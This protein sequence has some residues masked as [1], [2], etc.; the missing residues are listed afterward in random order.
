MPSSIDVSTISEMV[1]TDFVEKL[2]AKRTTSTD[3]A[4]NVFNAVIGYVKEHPVS[5]MRIMLTGQMTELAQHTGIKSLDNSIGRRLT[6]FYRS[7][8]ADLGMT[9]RG[10]VFRSA[11][12][13]VNVDDLPVDQFKIRTIRPSTPMI[14][15]AEDWKRY[16]SEQMTFAME[17]FNR[18]AAL[19]SRYLTDFEH[20]GF[21]EN[22]A[23]NLFGLF[24][25]TDYDEAKIKIP[26]F[27]RINEQGTQA[28]YIVDRD[29]T[30]EADI[31]TLYANY[32]MPYKEYY[33]WTGYELERFLD[34]M[35]NDPDGMN[36]K[37]YDG[38]YRGK[39]HFVWDTINDLEFPKYLYSHD[40]RTTADHY[41][42]TTHQLWKILERF[43]EVKQYAEQCNESSDII[44]P[45]MLQ[46]LR[47]KESDYLEYI[48]KDDSR[49]LTCKKWLAAND[50]NWIE[51]KTFL[52]GLGYVRNTLYDGRI[53]I[54]S[55]DDN[56]AMFIPDAVRISD[57]R[58]TKLHLMMIGNLARDCVPEHIDLLKRLN[59][60]TNRLHVQAIWEQEFDLAQAV[61]ADS[62]KKRKL[63]GELSYHGVG[64]VNAIDV[65]ELCEFI[66]SHTDKETIEYYH[67]TTTP[68]AFMAYLTLRHITR[69]EIQE[70]KMFSNPFKTRM[71]Q[72]LP[73]DADRIYNFGSSRSGRSHQQLWKDATAEELQA[74]YERQAVWSNYQSNSNLRRKLLI[75]MERLLLHENRIDSHYGLVYRELDDGTVEIPDFF[76]SVPGR[77]CDVLFI[78]DEIADEASKKQIMHQFDE[79]RRTNI[80]RSGSHSIIGFASSKTDELYEILSDPAVTRTTW[81][82]RTLKQRCCYLKDHKERIER[83]NCRRKKQESENAA[84][85]E[86]RNRRVAREAEEARIREEQDQRVRDIASLVP[87]SA[88]LSSGFFHYIENKET[89]VSLMKYHVKH[90]LAFLT[91]KDDIP[92]ELENAYNEYSKRRKLREE[93]LPFMETIGYAANNRENPR[94]LLYFGMGHWLVPD[95][96]GYDDKKRFNVVFLLDRNIVDESKFEL[97][98]AAASVLSKRHQCVRGLWSG[99]QFEQFKKSV[100]DSTVNWSAYRLEYIGKGH[101]VWDMLNDPDFMRYYCSHSAQETADYYGVKRNQLEHVVYRYPE[102]KRPDDSQR[103][104]NIANARRKTD[105]DEFVQMD[106]VSVSKKELEL[107]EPLK[108]LGILHN[109]KRSLNAE[110]AIIFGGAGIKA[111]HPDYI[112]RDLKIIVEFDG[113]YYHRDPDEAVFRQMYYNWRGYQVSIVWEDE[114][115]EFLASPPQTIEELLERYPCTWRNETLMQRGYAMEHDFADYVN[116]LKALRKMK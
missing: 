16:D 20:Q 104:R 28:I 77:A 79:H 36:W 72:Q 78:N 45:N 84:R 30:S 67:L 116:R 105:D 35:K 60:Q 43:P 95:F 64:T 40:A 108:A 24:V 114:L 110:E 73:D 1:V 57:S 68:K 70:K 65:D 102:F 49:Y 99:F 82:N 15:D 101:S 26:D 80:E 23:D 56:G 29:C 7:S 47:G 59:K 44:T 74:L 115:D 54:V 27:M 94:G 2:T 61:C 91:L 41:G 31:K 90:P 112:S 10:L 63:I 34:Q 92:E 12:G 55:L 13:L 75:P 9:E 42:L 22:S 97:I 106:G 58:T 17:R 113:A 87:N 62:T 39:G 25:R 69:R 11:F 21:F 52:M 71:R 81:S 86:S 48:G 93:L 18:N 46:Q 76:D 85:I 14:R 33:V 8:I 66:M 109:D 4:K 111:M 32:G 51:H 6:G 100:A 5:F 89:A 107:C 3:Q 96:I 37:V 19:R 88:G 83:Q 98:K 38:S 103:M 50:A 53:M